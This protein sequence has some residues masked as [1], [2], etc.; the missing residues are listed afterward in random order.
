MSVRGKWQGMLTIARFNWPFYAAA[1]AVMI[2]SLAGWLLLSRTGL[3]AACAITFAVTAYFLVGSLSVSHFIYDRSDLYRWNWLERAL[4]GVNMRQVIFCHC[5]FDEASPALCKRFGGVQW[6]LLNHFD[7]QQMTEASIRR[8]RA[9]F[10]PA[11][12]T[13]PAR[14]DVW[15]LAADS[16]DVVLALLAIHELRSEAERSAWMAECRRCLRESGRVVLVEQVRD[17]ANFL[18]FGPGFLHF[19]S[20]ASWRRCWESAGLRST[21]EFRVTPF[22]R[23]FVLSKT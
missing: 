20:P 11:P 23:I 8:A 13:L 15:P 14:Y 3:R 5:G 1:V 4:R 16:A 22:V 18:A 10:P 17:A 6:Q 9:M 2:A 19:H 12:G 21:A 7:Q